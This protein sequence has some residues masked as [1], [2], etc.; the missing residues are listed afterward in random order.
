MWSLGICKLV[1][2]SDMSM[3]SLNLGIDYFEFVTYLCMDFPHFFTKLLER[4]TSNL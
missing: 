4:N 2:N 1:I 3:P